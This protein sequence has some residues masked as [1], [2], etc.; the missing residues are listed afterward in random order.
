M[1]IN[2]KIVYLVNRKRD[3]NPINMPNDEVN[4]E[5]ITLCNILAMIYSNL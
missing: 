2:Y 1:P 5:P 4:V 3:S